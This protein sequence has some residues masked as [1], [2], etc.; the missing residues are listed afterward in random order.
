MNVRPNSAWAGVL[1]YKAQLLHQQIAAMQ[2]LAA[3]AGATPERLEQACAPYY[4]LLDEI[5]AKDVPVARALDTADLLLHLDGEG[6]QTDSPRLSLVSSI[7]GDVRKQVGTMIKTLV[8]SLDEKVELPRE[9]DLGLC[10]FAFGSLY[11]GFAVPAPPPGMIELRGDP[12]FSASREA[13]ALLGRVTDHIE[14]ADA[15]AH[16]CRDLA[17]PKL[18]DAALSAVGQ[19]A[20]SGRRGVSSVAIG[21]R[22]LPDRPWRTL[23]PETRLQIRSWLEKPVLGDEVIELNGRVR[24][25][26]TCAGSISAAST[27]VASPTCVASIRRRSTSRQKSG[28]TASS[29]CAAGWRPITVPRACCRWKAFATTCGRTRVALCDLD[30]PAQG[31]ILLLSWPRKTL[32]RPR[33]ISSATMRSSTGSRPIPR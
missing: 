11:L 5:Y 18:R 12:L 22:A 19:L 2:R 17:D 32:K 29:S 25:T 20:P 27:A 16:I 28:S 9:I 3:D 23:T 6:L 15:Y 7:M 21:G 4:R 30:A 24:S 1:Q 13:L 26:S 33:P 10:S 8:S 31:R 14:E